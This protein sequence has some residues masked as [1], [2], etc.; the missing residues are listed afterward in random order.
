[1]GIWQS[2]LILLGIGIVSERFGA[3]VGLGQLGVGIRELAGAPLGGLGTGLGEFAGGLRAIAESFGDIGRG[4][5]EMF[6]HIP[7]FG[8]KGFP[9]QQPSRPGITNGNGLYGGGIV[10]PGYP[11]NGLLTVSGGDR[12]TDLT[13]GGGNVPRGFNGGGIIT[14]PPPVTLPPPQITTINVGHTGGSSGA[15]GAPSRGLY[16]V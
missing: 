8:R 7:E 6:K 11:G 12:T 5:G 3:G 13:G 9:P 4:F 1:M 16:F 10:P 2:A 14:I 15:G